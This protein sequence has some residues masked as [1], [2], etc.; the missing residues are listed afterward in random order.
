MKEIW[1]DIIWYEWKYQISNLGRARSLD[2]WRKNWKTSQ[3]YMKWCI[4]KPSYDKNGYIV[5]SSSLKWH[6][7]VAKAFIPNP[8]NKPCVNHKN[9]IKDDNRVENLEWVTYS[10]NMRHSFDVLWNTVKHNKQVNQY[11]LNWKFIKTW[12][13]IIEAE[14]YLKQYYPTLWLTCSA[15]RKVLK[16]KWKTAYWY[17]WKYL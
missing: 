4:L 7:L 10:E 5:Y 12:N 1:K 11:D 6:R 9:W 16:W 2:R 13:S 15:I 8:E 17:K 14:K 3:Y